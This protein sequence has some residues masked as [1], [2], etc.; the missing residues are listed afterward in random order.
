MYKKGS[1]LTFCFWGVSCSV[2][3]SVV[4]SFLPLVR[5]ASHLP[6]LYGIVIPS[7]SVNAPGPDSPD[8]GR[9]LP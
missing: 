4:S 7:R 5:R 3:T 1:R 9:A 6:R 2:V 8:R